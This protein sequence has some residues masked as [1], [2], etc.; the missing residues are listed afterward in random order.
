MK[1]AIA[2]LLV[3]LMLA[4]A[5][6]SAA[7]D[8]TCY[9]GQVTAIDGNRVAVLLVS[10]GELPEAEALEDLAQALAAGTRRTLVLD[11]STLLSA[12]SAGSDS[13]AQLS[14][15]VPGSLLTVS[16]QGAALSSVV[17]WQDGLTAALESVARAAD[18]Q[19][20]EIPL[21]GQRVVD[22]TAV[23]YQDVS[24]ESALPGQSALLARGGSDVSLTGTI[25]AKQADTP[26]AEES[27]HYGLN[28]A[29]T[30]ISGS[31]VYVGN[32]TVSA[33]GAGASAAFASGESSLMELNNAAMQ[34][35]GAGA[36]GLAASHGASIKG[37]EAVI[38]TSGEDSP[39]VLVGVGGGSLSL[40]GSQLATA[41]LR[42]PCLSLAGNGAVT[43]SS[44]AAAASPAVMQTAGTLHLEACTFS[45]TEGAV[46]DGR[47]SVEEDSPVLTISEGTLTALSGP[48]FEAVGTGSLSL[49]GVA[50]TAQSGV[51]LSATEAQFTLSADAQTLT[52]SVEL[53]GD[54]AV[55]LAL[56][57]GSSLTGT[58]NEANQGQLI[59]SLSEDSVWNVTGT[60]YIS[61]LSDGDASLSNIRDNGH[62]IYY[63]AANAANAWL[64][65]RDIQLSGGGKL[66]AG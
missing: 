35:E 58:L 44:G 21:T 29:L 56:A 32:S 23:A 51:L 54:S 16:F 5:P 66:A 40:A 55:T 27:A 46:I 2:A 22:A 28:S 45:G 19:T 3:G 17:I 50:L 64:D 37:T 26:S 43:G 20:G 62:T 60:S 8:E 53:S 13:P 1:Q 42:S 24:F 9:L 14:D 4:T 52:G 7:P 36:Y 18:S 12:H 6:A 34:T 48:L 25:I 47:E 41:G 30:A 15:L 63:D 65:G 61:A 11:D 49:S 10:P 59:L 33:S 57:N 31:R 38:S 39:A